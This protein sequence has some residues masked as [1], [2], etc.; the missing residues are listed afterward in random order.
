[1]VLAAP[2][3]AAFA[4]AG[5][6][7]AAGA[8]V[9]EDASTAAFLSDPNSQSR[10]ALSAAF[11]PLKGP[12][13]LSGKKSFDGDGKMEFNGGFTPNYDTVLWIASKQRANPTLNSQGLYIQHRVSGNLNGLVND[14][15]ASELRLSGVTN[16]G[17]GQSAQE[18]SVVVGGAENNASLVCSTLSNMNVDSSATGHIE[19]MNMIRGSQVQPKGGL[20]VG[21]AVTIHLDAQIIG[22]KNYTVWANGDSAFSRFVPQATNMPVIDARGVNGQTGNIMS[23]STVQDV[24]FSVTAQGTS[25]IGPMVAEAQLSTLSGAPAR[26]AFIARAHGSQTSKILDVQNSVGK[27]FV[28][29][30]A[31]GDFRTVDRQVSFRNTGDTATTFSLSGKGPRWQ[32]VSTTR[33]NAGAAGAA[34]AL[35]AKPELYMKVYGPSGVELLIPAYK[36]P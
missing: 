2:F 1:V 17:A 25:H 28:Y 6:P 30:A 10:A 9:G 22:N 34:T 29:V 12:A 21:K 3:L 27:S 32:G 20:T 19:Q 18:N 31:N 16:T 7:P 11:V 4:A 14:A 8:T 5:A 23:V 26:V 35:P 24:V 36:A 13:T 15:G 33:I